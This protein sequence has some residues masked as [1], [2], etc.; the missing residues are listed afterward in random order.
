MNSTY[1]KIPLPLSFN[2]LRKKAGINPLIVNYHVVS[3]NYIPYVKNLYSYRNVQRFCEDLDFFI[4]NY[5][6]I[7]LL[8][9]L[10]CIK[11]NKKIPENAVLFTIDD[12]FREVYDIMAPMMLERNLTATVFLTSGFVDNNQFGFDQKKS[13][14]MD[15]VNQASDPSLSNKL[16]KEL[17]LNNLFTN[18][19]SYSIMNIPYV[20]GYI[21]DSLS[22]TIDLDFNITL[23][24]FSPFLTTLQI[25]ELMQKGFTI[26]GHSVDHPNFAELS[27]Q[28]QVIQAQNSVDFVTEKFAVKYKV[29]AFP[30]WD[31][32]ISREFFKK[33]SVDATF[34][35]QG[36]LTDT[37][38]TNFQRIGIEKYNYTAKRIIK[39]HYFRKMIYHSLK[40]DT[41]TRA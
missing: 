30:Y 19:L 26:G 17:E 2:F 1:F 31:G 32:G 40:K 38:Q 5:N 10:D 18:S 34:G 14:L 13:L 9:F 28:D 23:K 21:L 25:T 41:L 24:Q 3:D 6:P 29:F 4:S 37:I 7:G 8:E 15:K 39:A 11:N 33:L 22:K 20:K 16:R 27:I 12:G 36:L 35:T